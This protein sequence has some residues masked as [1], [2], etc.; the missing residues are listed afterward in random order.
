MTGNSVAL[1]TNHAIHLLN[2]DPVVVEWLKGFTELC[3]PATVL[4][5]LRFGSM[6]SARPQ[7]NL[8]KVDRLAARCTNIDV[9]AKTADVYARLRLQLLRK[10]R[11]IPE[12]DVWI[13]ATCLEHALP[14]ATTDGH[15]THVEGLRVLTA[16]SRP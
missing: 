11:P 9:T 7:A 4:G 5:E 10:G 16:P 2:D 15:F 12:N 13:A 3:L 8:A 14:L 6:K 1:D